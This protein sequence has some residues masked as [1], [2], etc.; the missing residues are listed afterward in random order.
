MMFQSCWPFKIELSSIES[1]Y[2]SYILCPLIL[3]ELSSR[4][5]HPVIHSSFILSQ[6]MILSIQSHPVIHLSSYYRQSYH[7]YIVT[8]HSSFILLWIEL[9]SIL[10][11]F[12]LFIYSFFIQTRA[13]L[14]FIH[15]LSSHIQS[16]H[17]NRVIRWQSKSEIFREKTRISPLLLR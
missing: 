3:S 1:S 16:Y 9:S 7:P 5:S 4:H 14:S 12:I 8:C 17:P 11:H 6:I 15:P 10:I 13:I 2:H